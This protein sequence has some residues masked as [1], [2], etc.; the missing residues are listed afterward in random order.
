LTI[1]APSRDGSRRGQAIT[2]QR[3]NEIGVGPGI[4]FEPLH[5]RRAGCEFDEKLEQ[6]AL[7]EA[8]D[9]ARQVGETFAGSSRR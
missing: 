6:R 7:A 3:G 2:A 5:E 8:M 4:D 1:V 9:F